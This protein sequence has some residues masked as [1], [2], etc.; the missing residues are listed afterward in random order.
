MQRKKAERRADLK[1]REA[2]KRREQSASYKARSTFD[3]YGIRRRAYDS[4]PENLSMR[5]IKPKKNRV[6]AYVDYVDYVDFVD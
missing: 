3:A 4:R 2:N 5:R 1:N 6:R